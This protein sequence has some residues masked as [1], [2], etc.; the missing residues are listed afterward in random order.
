MSIDSL[1]LTSVLIWIAWIYW[2]HQCCTV[3]HNK[4]Q[5]WAKIHIEP[6]D[7]QET[8]SFWSCDQ[9]SGLLYC[10]SCF[11]ILKPHRFQA[12]DCFTT[13]FHRFFYVRPSVCLEIT[14]HFFVEEEK[15]KCMENPNNTSVLIKVLAVSAA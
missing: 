2:K 12:W 10:F 1:H 14:S 4:S 8:S 3:N 13:V 7:E 9:I 11:G 5:L 15:K 6:Y